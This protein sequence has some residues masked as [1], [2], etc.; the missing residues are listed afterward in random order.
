MIFAIWRTTTFVYRSKR[1][2]F[3]RFWSYK[4]SSHQKS[5]DPNDE[6]YNFACYFKP[7]LDEVVQ[8]ETLAGDRG[9]M[10]SGASTSA[11]LIEPGGVQMEARG[12]E[13]GG[14]AS[15]RGQ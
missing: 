13:H 6:T 9:A 1:E 5:F 14:H 7:C 10:P 15:R 11:V 2:S 8:K 3:N 4:L 12:T